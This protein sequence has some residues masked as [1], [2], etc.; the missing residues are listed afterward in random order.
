MAKLCRSQKES[1]GLS[2]EWFLPRE[3]SGAVE[4]PLAL[5]FAVQYKA[6]KTSD[7]GVKL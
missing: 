4:Q 2:N 7:K 3:V 1:S 6:V 5:Q